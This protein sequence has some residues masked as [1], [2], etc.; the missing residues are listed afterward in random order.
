MQHKK[1]KTSV[2]T[3]FASKVIIFQETF[4]YANVIN[5]YYTWQSSALQ[6]KVPNG[7]TWTIARTITKTLNLVVHQCLLN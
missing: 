4:E 5:I 2:K 3:H 1:F 6:A 7:L